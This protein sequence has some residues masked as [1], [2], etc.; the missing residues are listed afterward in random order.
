MKV[1]LRSS[2]RRQSSPPLS[3]RP[4]GAEMTTVRSWSGLS[5]RSPSIGI[6]AVAFAQHRDGPSGRLR[7]ARLG[8]SK[9]FQSQDLS[10]SFSAQWQQTSWAK[11]W[12]CWAGNYSGRQHRCPFAVSVATNIRPYSIASGR[13]YCGR[14]RAAPRSRRHEG[15]P[16]LSFFLHCSDRDHR[17]LLEDGPAP[18]AA[19]CTACGQNAMQE[20]RAFATMRA[21]DGCE[22]W[23]RRISSTESVLNQ[24][25]KIYPSQSDRLLDEHLN[26]CVLT[27]A[28]VI[29][30]VVGSITFSVKKCFL[31]KS[32]ERLPSDSVI[33]KPPSVALLR[34]RMCLS[35]R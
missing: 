10:S 1:Y 24:P 26:N 8:P 27:S 9:R 5:T 33:W 3:R 30:M 11:L 29:S 19:G 14:G 6:S 31:E 34:D 32:S 2:R 12:A 17:G 7:S 25:S 35:A 4:I 28:S 23:T 18:S 22:D 15:W 21:D 13:S 16:A 20:R